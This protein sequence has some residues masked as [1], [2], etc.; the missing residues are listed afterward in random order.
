MKEIVLRIIY[1]AIDEIN[2]KLDIDQKLAKQPDTRLC[3]AG[4]HFDSLELINLIE[5]VEHKIEDFYQE[6]I[7]LADE[8][9]MQMAY[10]PF[11]TISSF[12]EFVEMKVD[13]MTI[14]TY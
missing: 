10:T 12:A 7:V 14:K 13:E 1:E 3:G 2:E 8:R 6:E 9:V 4:V 5:L 11:S